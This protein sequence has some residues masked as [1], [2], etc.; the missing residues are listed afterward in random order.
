MTAGM[1]RP[2]WATS[3]ATRIGIVPLRTASERVSSSSARQERDAVKR[4]ERT[5]V[6]R[7]VA[8]RLPLVAV[9]R[10]RLER[11][12]LG[13]TEPVAQVLRGALGRAKD[14]DLAAL[15]GLAVEQLEEFVGGSGLT[16]QRRGEARASKEGRQRR[17]RQAH[18][19]FL[20]RS[21]PSHTTTSCVMARLA[22]TS[23]APTVTLAASLT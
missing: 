22:D 12:V 1:S 19:A 11:A 18:L 4:G 5:L 14:E 20:S 8:L 2:R 23:S 10:H 21:P 9:E 6:E 16:S 17:G 13:R 7:P 3:V 15:V